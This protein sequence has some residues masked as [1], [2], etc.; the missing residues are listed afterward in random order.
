MHCL[1]C[2]A[3]DHGETPEYAVETCKGDLLRENGNTSR[4]TDDKGVDRGICWLHPY[5]GG[6]NPWRGQK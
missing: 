1:D 5:R 4:W 3:L 6:K 2:A